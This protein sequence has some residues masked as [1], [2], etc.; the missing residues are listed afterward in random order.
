MYLS[1]QVGSGSVEKKY[2][3]LQADP[4]SLIIRIIWTSLHWLWGGES[5]PIYSVARRLCVQPSHKVLT[6]TLQPLSHIFFYNPYNQKIHIMDWN[7]NLIDS[8]FMFMLKATWGITWCL[9]Q[10]WCC[11][12][13]CNH[14]INWTWVVEE[15]LAFG[16]RLRSTH[17]KEFNYLKPCRPAYFVRTTQLLPHPGH[18]WLILQDPKRRDDVFLYGGEPG[19]H[20]HRVSRLHNVFHAVFDLFNISIICETMPE[21]ERE[22][23]KIKNPNIKNIQ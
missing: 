2:R 19:P 20:V 1:L 10:K 5:E 18:E 14:C 9:V 15:I 6:A 13:P 23:N 3:V 21:R 16:T 4:H 7:L 22:I 12:L 17:C 11:C 8:L